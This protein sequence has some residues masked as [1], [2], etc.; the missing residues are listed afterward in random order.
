MFPKLHPRKGAPTVCSGIK[1]LRYMPKPILLFLGLLLGWST[2]YG[3]TCPPETRESA[4]SRYEVV[5]IGKAIETVKFRSLWPRDTLRSRRSLRSYWLVTRMEVH[6]FA[7]GTS[8]SDTV[9]VVSPPDI[10]SCRAIFGPG[11]LYVVF[12]DRLRLRRK[13][14]NRSPSVYSTSECTPTR[15]CFDLPC[16]DSKNPCPRM[17]CQS[18]GEHRNLHVP[19]GR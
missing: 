11:A 13:W 5:F 15:G 7:K 2:T 8:A 6:S 1:Y 12:A 19:R 17:H 3:C 10:G 16:P 9:A 14:F 4:F 18:L